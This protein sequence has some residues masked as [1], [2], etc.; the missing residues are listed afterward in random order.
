MLLAAILS[1]NLLHVDEAEVAI[2]GRTEKGYVWV[3]TNMDAVYYF[4]K[5]SR[6]GDFLEEMLRRVLGRAR[7]GLLYRL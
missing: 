1:G 3:L 4:Y 2:K 5:D 7:V 6:K